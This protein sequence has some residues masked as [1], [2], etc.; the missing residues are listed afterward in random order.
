MSAQLGPD[1]I[2]QLITW[3]KAT[4]R[5]DVI[6]MMQMVAQSMDKGEHDV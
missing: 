3:E 4:S 5:E 1:M 6:A 2:D